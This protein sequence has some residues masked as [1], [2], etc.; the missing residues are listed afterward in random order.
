[1]AI[2][3]FVSIPKWGRD[4][5]REGG[6]AYPARLRPQDAEEV[7]G[8]RRRH[9]RSALPDTQNHSTVSTWQMKYLHSMIPLKTLYHEFVL[10]FYSQHQSSFSAL[11]SVTVEPNSTLTKILANA[12]VPMYP[13][14]YTNFLCCYFIISI[15]CVPNLCTISTSSLF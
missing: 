6:G 14:Y 11:V 4:S 8:K 1:M 7:V 13:C 15:S 5:E 12:A 9:I 10:P 3:G 2:S